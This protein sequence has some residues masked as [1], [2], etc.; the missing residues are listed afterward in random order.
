MATLIL[1]L[2]F[3]GNTLF[4]ILWQQSSFPMGYGSQSVHVLDI[5]V[6]AFKEHTL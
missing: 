3:N 4:I 1:V 6:L 5:F 2:S